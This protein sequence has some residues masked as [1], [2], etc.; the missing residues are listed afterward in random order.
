M[1]EPFVWRSRVRFS[2]TD[3]SG[4]IH[5]SAMFRY[6]EATEDEFLRAAGIPYS[7][8]EPSQGVSFPRVHVEAQFMAALKYDDVVD[9]ELSVERVGETSFTLYFDAS[10]EGAPVARGRMTVV[11]IS[12]ATERPVALP[13]E[14]AAA[15]ERGGSGVE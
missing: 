2:E 4:R 12:V 13:A 14:M 10:R 8:F 9:M 15:L 7:R 3:S 1:P 11:C 6:L 5:Y